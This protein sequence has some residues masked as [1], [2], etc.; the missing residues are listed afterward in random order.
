MET[1]ECNVWNGTYKVKKSFSIFP[2]LARM[3]LTKL[4]L[5]GNNLYMTSLFPP[6]A[7]L[8]SDIPALDRNIEKLFYGVSTKNIK[9]NKNSGIMISNL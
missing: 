4:Y 3:S 2:S 6:M 1:A 7:C 5:G 9:I 8:V